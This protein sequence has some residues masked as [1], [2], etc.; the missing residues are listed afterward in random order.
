MAA[1]K[2]VVGVASA[3]AV[4]GQP[5]AVCEYSNRGHWVDVCTQGSDVGT[6]DASG[7]LVGANGTSFAAP[8]IAGEIVR[9]AG[10]HSIGLR[11]S[12]TM[13][14]RDLGKPVIFGGGTF[15]DMPMP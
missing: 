2:R 15:V 11:D 3:A 14:M 9:V 7:N 13:I 1:Y 4:N 6:L 10:L 8:K 5:P 12:A